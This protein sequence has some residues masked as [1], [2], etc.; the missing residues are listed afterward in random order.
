MPSED[1]EEP[2][3]P[4]QFHDFQQD[5]YG[6]VLYAYVSGSSGSGYDIRFNNLPGNPGN[7]AFRVEFSAT[8]GGTITRRTPETNP[9]Y[10]AKYS[11][12]KLVDGSQSLVTS[13]CRGTAC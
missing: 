12:I 9:S 2:G 8:K 5:L 13:W 7:V 3:L 11:Q 4:D 1:P 6:N 10:Q